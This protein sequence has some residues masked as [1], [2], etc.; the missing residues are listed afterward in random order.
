NVVSVGEA[1]LHLKLQ[2]IVLVGHA[3]ALIGHGLRPAELFEVRPARVVVGAGVVRI[4]TGGVDVD[5]IA[6]VD[7]GVAAA[8]GDVS[9]RY[10]EVPGKLALNRRIVNHDTRHDDPTRPGANLDAVGYRERAVT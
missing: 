7:K 3:T 10:H 9:D 1:F 6:V 2:G 5:R 4:P 8:V